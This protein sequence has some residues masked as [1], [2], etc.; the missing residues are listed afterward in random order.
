M[1][2]RARVLATLLYYFYKSLVPTSKNGG[3]L[4]QYELTSSAGHMYS[5]RIETNSRSVTPPHATLYTQPLTLDASS[6]RLG[7]RQ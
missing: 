4:Q 7:G 5:T 6:N 1:T 3:I 2:F